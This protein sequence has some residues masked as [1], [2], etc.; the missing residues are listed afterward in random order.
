MR[1]GKFIVL[2]GV[3]GAGKTSQSK[4]LAAALSAKG[5]DVVLTREPGGVPLA[6]RLR[7]LILDPEYTPDAL[8]ELYM[9]MAA[10]RE[11]LNKVIVPALAAGKT[12]IC[13]RFTYST[14]AYQGYGRGVDKEF[15]RTLNAE[16]V[17]SV[18]VDIALFLDV[19]PAVGFARKGG[20]D[21]GDRMESG[22]M[23]FFERIYDGFKKMCAAGELTA[24]DATVGEEQTAERILKAVESVL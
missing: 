6:E 1:Q 4:R 9:Y 17:K 24:I 18:N 19:P 15:I 14:L 13:D 22:G 20:A 21:C 2:E 7:E 23:Q 8:T 5:M 10:R 12:V 11:H 3:E 16:T